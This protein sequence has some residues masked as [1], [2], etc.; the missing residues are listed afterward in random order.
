MSLAYANL[1]DYADP[2]EREKRNVLKE[3]FDLAR[4]LAQLS[5]YIISRTSEQLANG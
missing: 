4:G 2:E 1:R 3:N 5:S